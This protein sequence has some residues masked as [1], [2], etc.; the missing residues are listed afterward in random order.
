MIPPPPKKK[1]CK[2][3][4]HKKLRY[5]YYYQYVMLYAS[6]GITWHGCGE[7]DCAWRK[8]I[9]TDF[10]FYHDYMF[11]SA[12]SSIIHTDNI[13]SLFVFLRSHFCTKNYKIFD[14]FLIQIKW[15]RCELQVDVCIVVG[16]IWN[17]CVQ[18][19]ISKKERNLS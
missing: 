12:L 1:K 16:F 10:S 7:L 19:E 18:W 17:S 3:N 11:Y 9:G 5:K 6:T 8:G 4:L 2:N 13:I 15:C 14:L